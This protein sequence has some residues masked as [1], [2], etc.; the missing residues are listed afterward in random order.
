MIHFGVGRGL[1]LREPCWRRRFLIVLLPSERDR[2]F[3]FPQ[4][5]HQPFSGQ[6]D[7]EVPLSEA[8]HQVEGLPPRLLLGQGQGVLGHALFDHRP[9]VRRRPE[10]T[11]RGYGRLDA[12]VRTAEVVGL[13]EEG[14][15][16]L[17][18]LEVGENRPRQKLVPE[19][20]PEAFDLAQGL[21]VVRTALDVVDP[22]ALEL[23]LEVGVAAPGR[24]LPALIGQH[25]P[26]RTVLGD[27]PREGLHHQRGAL[28]MRNHQRHHVPRAV[29]HEGGDV[30]PLMPSQQ[31]CEDVRLP[32]LVRF[33]A[34]EAMLGRTRLGDLR[35]Y[36]LQQSL[37]V[38]DPPYRRFRHSEP[39]EACQK[40]PDPSRPVLR[41][42]PSRLDDRRASWVRLPPF[43]ASLGSPITLFRPPANI[44][45]VLAV[46][47][48]P[49]SHRRHR[50]P[51][52]L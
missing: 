23:R 19:R 45:S 9:H 46:A 5:H 28:M 10:E 32:E 51:E 30:E 31:E 3:H 13:D 34:L 1:S 40:V 25:L 43:R 37:F 15:A 21:R 8:A 29:V 4:P 2:L 47:A 52:G 44:C 7:G 36:A 12:L 27:S 18:V 6:G 20:L 41:M 49:L 17:A 39:I 38:E 50:N 16:P 24:V 48:R 11:I 35:R 14:H 33:R 42:L 26:R 22:L